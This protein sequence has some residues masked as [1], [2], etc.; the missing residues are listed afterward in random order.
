MRL[1]ERAVP[2]LGARGEG[3][4]ALQLVLLAATAA[5]ALLGPA[6]PRPL[7]PL[8]GPL[9]LVLLGG[10]V[11][12]ALLAASALGRSL[13]PL[14]RPSAQGALCRRG[15]YRSARHPIYGGLLLIAFGWSLAQTPL[16][17]LP[18]GAL[19]AVLVLKSHAEEAWLLERYPEY[20]L[21]RADTPARFV[22]RL[23]RGRGASAR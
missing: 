11:L 21:Y 8:L 17:L 18:S 2:R 15:V 16:A 13:T 9:G 6:W 1:R 22:P 3:W 4:V 7:R 20:A 23:L 19:A 12:L 14:P 10:G 5:C